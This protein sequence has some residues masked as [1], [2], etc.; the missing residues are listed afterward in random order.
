M[1]SYL[2]EV[3]DILGQSAKILMTVHVLSAKTWMMNLI[4]VSKILIGIVAL[5]PDHKVAK[6]CSDFV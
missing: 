3:L 2:P 4:Y 6:I 1:S 5:K